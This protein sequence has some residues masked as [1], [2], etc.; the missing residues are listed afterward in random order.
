[1]AY[2]IKYSIPIFRGLIYRESEFYKWCK[3]DG[4][5]PLIPSIVYKP[6]IENLCGT[7]KSIGDIR[8]YVLYIIFNDG[9]KFVLSSTPEK[10]LSLY[11]YE[12]YFIYDHSTDL[13][14][15]SKSSYYL[16]NENLGADVFFKE[17]IESKFS[18]YRT[19]Y[20][21]RECPEC[22]FVFGA[23]HDYQ[24]HNPDNFYHSIIDKFENFSLD[25]L[26]KTIDLIKFHNP[27]Y[28]RSIILNDKFYRK[29]IIKRSYK[30]EQQLTKREVECLYWAAHGKS[31]DETAIILKIKKNT[32]E[33]YRKNIKQKL[34]CSSMAH[35]IY[36]GVK[37][38]YIGA[39][40]RINSE[41]FNI[42]SLNNDIEKINYN[43]GVLLTPK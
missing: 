31:S 27:A 21:M 5:T 15:F 10:F 23:L 38:G 41:F 32:V 2:Q 43:K 30:A 33:D 29:S 7:L 13:N 34:N 8:Y 28:N 12:K 25:F 40:H 22:R 9:Q 35:A 4:N 26:E 11:W 37:R 18:M 16:C 24:I 36:E 39:F 17:T 19:F 42:P 14:L 6:T 3:M 20:T 1:M